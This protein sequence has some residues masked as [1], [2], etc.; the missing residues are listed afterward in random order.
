VA[1][2][3]VHFKFHSLVFT[4]GVPVGVWLAVWKKF[5]AEERAAGPRLTLFTFCRI[6]GS[7]RK[8]VA[9]GIGQVF[10]LT[11]REARAPRDRTTVDRSYA[12]DL[13]I[14]NKRRW[15]AE[16]I[17]AGFRKRRAVCRDLLA[18]SKHN[19][20]WIDENVLRRVGVADGVGQGTPELNSSTEMPPWS[21]TTR[22]NLR[23]M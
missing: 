5:A 21:S 8:Q 2:G 9:A 11:R 19:L 3:L 20:V 6:R 1:E 13:I 12:G 16:G 4:L 14:R 22:F 15:M 17:N 18:H 23:S 10:V 7:G